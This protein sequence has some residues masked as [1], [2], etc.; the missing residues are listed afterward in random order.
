MLADITEAEW[1]LDRLCESLNRYTRRQSTRVSDSAPV[2]PSDRLRIRHKLLTDLLATKW[3]SGSADRGSI[4]RARQ[5]QA[6]A[7]HLGRRRAR[8]K[9]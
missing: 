1:V 5:S 3:S 8:S 4:L 2:A 6:F 9:S 7:V